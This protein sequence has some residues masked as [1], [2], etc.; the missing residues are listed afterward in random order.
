MQRVLIIEDEPSITVALQFLLE[1]EGY[2]VDCAADGE[3][4][5]MRLLQSR[6]NVLVLD[7]MLPNRSGFEVL[8]HIR[9][10]PRLRDLP[11]LVLTARGQAQDRRMA[12]DAGADAFLTKPFANAEVI[13]AM[14][15]LASERGT[16]P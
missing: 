6:P 3:S 10:A 2:H 15:R 7:V 1:R 9:G 14:K 12:K 13:A 11:V 4:G 8:K 16:T 5:L